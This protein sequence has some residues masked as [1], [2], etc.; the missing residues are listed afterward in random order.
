MRAVLCKEWGGPEKLT[1][2]DVSAPP[3]KAPVRAGLLPKTVMWLCLEESRAKG[4]A[5]AR[6]SRRSR[7]FTVDEPPCCDPILLTERRGTDCRW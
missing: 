1:V 7:R 2:E 3:I 5:T 6:S 4:F